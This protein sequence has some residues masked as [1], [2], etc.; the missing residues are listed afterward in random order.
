MPRRK[1]PKDIFEMTTHETLEMLFPQPVVDYLE[2][3]AEGRIEPPPPEPRKSRRPS[4]S[5][6]IT[7]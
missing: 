1:K 3:I 7:E 4:Q 6:P 2:G 5:K